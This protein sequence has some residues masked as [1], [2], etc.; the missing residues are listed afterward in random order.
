MKEEAAGLLNARHIVLCRLNNM[1]VRAAHQLLS[2]RPHQ[3]WAL[4]MLQC[5]EELSA[6]WSPALL[7]NWRMRACVCARGR[8]DERCSAYACTCAVAGPDH[9]DLARIA[10]DKHVAL[11]FLINNS[12]EALYS[13]FP[14]QYGTWQKAS[15]A[16]LAAKR[17]AAR[18]A[19]LYDHGA[20][21]TTSKP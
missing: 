19:A 20:P 11:D 21:E 1:A 15:K 6:T 13:A 4:L 12:P 9:C 3:Q 2:A 8:R 5:S 14:Q 7:G 10:H 17:E 18:I 16:E